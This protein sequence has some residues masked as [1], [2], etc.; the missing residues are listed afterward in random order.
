[1]DF[2]CNS[3]SLWNIHLIFCWQ[4]LCT[5]RDI[6]VMSLERQGSVGW[7]SAS[8]CH[9]LRHG[10]ACL[11]ACCIRQKPSAGQSS[12]GHCCA[13]CLWLSAG[14]WQFAAFVT[15]GLRQQIVYKFAGFIVNEQRT[16]Q[17]CFALFKLVDLASSPFYFPPF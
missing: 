3:A 11:M 12:F 6:C 1:M 8:R 5:H 2:Q 13:S 17:A 4:N 15:V 10:A 7:S 9:R 14:R 16:W